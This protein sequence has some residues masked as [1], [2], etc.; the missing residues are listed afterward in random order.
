[1][2]TTQDKAAE[3][4]ERRVGHKGD[5]VLGYSR[6]GKEEFWERELHAGENNSRVYEEAGWGLEGFE[7]VK[8][9]RDGKEPGWRLVESKASGTGTAKKHEHSD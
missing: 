9:G 5:L 1:M 7:Q 3:V 6:E 4:E 2:E 8:T